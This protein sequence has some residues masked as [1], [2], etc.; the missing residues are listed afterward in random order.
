[1]CS[2]SSIAMSPPSGLTICRRETTVV[3]SHSNQWSTLTVETFRKW[4]TTALGSMID[5]M[6]FLVFNA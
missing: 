6:L 2:G 1:M 4:L 3:V 5:I